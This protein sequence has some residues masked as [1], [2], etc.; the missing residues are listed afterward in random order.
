MRAFSQEF[1]NLHHRLDSKLRAQMKG[2][3]S[4]RQQL[5]RA[6]SNGAK[7]T[8]ETRRLILEAWLIAL[9]DRAAVAVSPDMKE[10]LAYEDDGLAEFVAEPTKLT[11]G[12]NS[13][14]GKID[15]VRRR[16]YVPYACKN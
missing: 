14:Q 10:F 5:E 2:L 12:A 8:V 11:A 16:A 7:I 15:K 9:C 6:G 4:P 13:G 3:S 1:L